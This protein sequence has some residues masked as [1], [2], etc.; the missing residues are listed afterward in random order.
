[1]GVFIKTG[2]E[3]ELDGAVFMTQTFARDFLWY[4]RSE[5]L[6]RLPHVWFG[7]TAEDQGTHIIIRKPDRYRFFEFHF[8]LGKQQDTTVEYIVVRGR[9]E[10]QDLSILA[11]SGDLVSS[12]SATRG[13]LPSRDA[14]KA[15]RILERKYGVRRAAPM[16][17]PERN[18]QTATRNLQCAHCGHYFNSDHPFFSEDFA[19]AVLLGR[20]IGISWCLHCGRISEYR[21]AKF[22]FFKTPFLQLSRT[23]P[24]EELLGQEYFGASFGAMG[25]LFGFHVLRMIWHAV[26][27]RARLNHGLEHTPLRTMEELLRRLPPPHVAFAVLAVSNTAHSLRLEEQL[28][29]GVY[30]SKSLSVLMEQ[31][32]QLLRDTPTLPHRDV[33]LEILTDARRRT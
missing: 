27:T 8:M 14:L 21:Q 11:R 25:G 20:N 6:E 4:G 17:I 3:A 29:L 26:D 2:W 16:P 15:V 31:A 10:L 18:G 7:S 5:V 24:V 1:M 30:Q 13:G 32:M 19:R 23:Y 28:E 22:L 9:D 33:V 12:L